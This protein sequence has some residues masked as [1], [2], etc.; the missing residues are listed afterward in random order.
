MKRL[1]ILDGLHRYRLDRHISSLLMAIAIGILSGY[2]A[3][4][5]RFAIQGAQYAFYQNAE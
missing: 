3:V 4:L 5:F 1:N 2:G